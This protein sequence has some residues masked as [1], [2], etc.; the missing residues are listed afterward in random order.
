MERVAAVV[1]DES[2]AAGLEV[3][4]EGGR[5]VVRGPRTQE[6]LARRLLERKAEVLALLAADEAEVAWRLEAMRP[7]V[8][9]RGPIPVLV[10]RDAPVPAGC[11]ISCGDGLREGR[12]FRC[13]PC[14]QAAGRVLDEVREGVGQ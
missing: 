1:L 3:R 9:P 6:G 2:R 10:A 13:S 5:L 11:C 4:A 14:A 12:R 7:Q 8:P